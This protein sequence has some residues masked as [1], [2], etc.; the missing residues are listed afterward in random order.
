[1]HWEFDGAKFEML[2]LMKFE[3][4]SYQDV[5]YLF[6]IKIKRTKNITEIDALQYT[7]AIYMASVFVLQPN[8]ILCSHP[9][10]E[11]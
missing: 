5:P 11:R 1:M 6:I 4:R 10:Q 7:D 3:Y 8:H 9:G 2:K